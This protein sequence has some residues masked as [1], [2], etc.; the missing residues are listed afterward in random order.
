MV[1]INPVKIMNETFKVEL[2]N[3]K[4]IHE[5]PNSWAEQD[6]RQLLDMMDYGETSDLSPEELREMCL[7]SLTDN[8]PGDAAKIVLEYVFGD[9]LTRGQINNLS[10]EMQDEKMWEE[11][12]DLSLHEE[13]FKA[14]QLL[15]E[16][17]D[18]TFPLPAAVK[19]QV[20]LTAKDDSAFS[21]FKNFPE[22]PLTRLLVAGMPDNTL[23]FRLFDDQI[24]GSEFRDAKD[25]IWQLKM[26]HGQKGQLLF[27]VISSHYW[28]H[29]LKFLSDFEGDTHADK[30]AP[31][32]G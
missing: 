8:E 4:T 14:N 25:I 17:F 29:D 6:Y 9:R 12:A 22:A 7:M 3:F 13:F 28:F 10:N 21:I 18:G 19:F 32:T 5:L 15:F 20:R 30:I 24:I 27:D 23:L 16:A 11:Y 1:V 2:L 31:A 26:D